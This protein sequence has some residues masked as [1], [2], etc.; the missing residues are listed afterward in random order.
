MEL[1]DGRMVSLIQDFVAGVVVIFGMFLMMCFLG[2]AVTS[3]FYVI[4][5]YAEW[6]GL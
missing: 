5:Q 2:L 4:T 6:L 1:G 3:A